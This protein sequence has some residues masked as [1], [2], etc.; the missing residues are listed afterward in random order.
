MIYRTSTYYKIK[1][2][3]AKIKVVQGGQGAGKNVAIAQILIEK[4]NEK[5]RIITIV[6]DT[7][8]NLKDGAIN[9]FKEQFESSDLNWNDA[10]NKTDHDLKI[11]KSIIQFRYVSDIK[12]QAG[13]SK[14]RDILYINEGNKIG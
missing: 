4:A 1:R 5:K 14:R 2:I 6:T 8:D 7:Y 10:F 3:R 12:K 13:K 9:D 11:G